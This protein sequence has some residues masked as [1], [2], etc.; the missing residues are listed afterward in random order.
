ITKGVDDTHFAPTL[1]CTRA[2]VVT[3]LWRAKGSQNSTAVV[4]FTDVKAD[5]YYTTAVAW[6]VENGIT[7]G[8]GDG[9]F[10][11]NVTCNR[12]YAVTFLYRAFAE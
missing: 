9:T 5:K 11:V 3:F 6:A 2:Q 1:D 10:G 12:A 8:M 7:T 4:E